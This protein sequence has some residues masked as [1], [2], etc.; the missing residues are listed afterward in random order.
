V[1]VVVYD[2]NAFT[3]FAS[4]VTSHVGPEVFE[5]GV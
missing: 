2:A 3:L 1:S 4:V 5:L